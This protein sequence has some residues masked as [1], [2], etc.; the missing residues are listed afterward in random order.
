[1]RGMG[2][3]KDG[4]AKEEVFEANTCFGGRNAGTWLQM[5]WKIG[6]KNMTVFQELTWIWLIH[7][8]D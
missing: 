7:G 6:V 2:N 1:M 8:N 5:R 4:E 3:E